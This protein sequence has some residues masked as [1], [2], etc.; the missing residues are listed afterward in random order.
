MPFN[1]IIMGIETGSLNTDSKN[2]IPFMVK[3]YF[4]TLLILSKT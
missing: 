2:K 3:I 1:Y 4:S